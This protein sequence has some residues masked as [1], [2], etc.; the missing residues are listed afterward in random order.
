MTVPGHKKQMI[1]IRRYQNHITQ[2]NPRH[3]DEEPQNTD[4]HKDLRHPDITALG[5]LQCTSLVMTSLYTV[6]APSGRA[7][8]QYSMC[9]LFLIMNQ[10][11]DD[12]SY[13]E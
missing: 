11:C 2:T 13:H 12:I 4:G 3:R 7:Y 10:I 9:R 1:I 5:S 6:S 8:A